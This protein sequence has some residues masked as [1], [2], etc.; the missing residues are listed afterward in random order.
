MHI[1]S[2]LPDSLESVCVRHFRW[3]WPISMK[4]VPHDSNSSTQKSPLMPETSLTSMS[5]KVIGI[6]CDTAWNLLIL[7]LTPNCRTFTR[8]IEKVSIDLLSPMPQIL[9]RRT[10]LSA[11]SDTAKSRWAWKWLSNTLRFKFLSGRCSKRA[12]VWTLPGLGFS[13]S[14]LAKSKSSYSYGGSHR[15]ADNVKSNHLA[16]S[17][18]NVRRSTPA[19]SMP[20]IQM[21]AWSSREHITLKI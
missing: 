3:S 16:W 11:G 9:T 21:E 18:L 2:T 4:K 13:H 14:S 8:E 15:S 19:G 7:P 12:F 6:K 5:Y 20:Y 10:C 1:I 17:C